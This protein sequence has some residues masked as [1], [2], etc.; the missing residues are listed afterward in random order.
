MPICSNCGT[1]ISGHYQGF[2]C[3][4][5]PKCLKEKETPTIEKNSLHLPTKTKTGV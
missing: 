2:P 3:D 5:C 1:E 4:L